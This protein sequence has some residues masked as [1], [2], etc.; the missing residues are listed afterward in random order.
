MQ[1]NQEKGGVVSRYNNESEIFWKKHLSNFAISGLKRV[2]YCQSQKI[3]YSR[4]SYWLAKLSPTPFKKIVN[5][6][7]ASKPLPLLSVQVTPEINQPDVLCSLTLKNGVTLKIH[8]LSALSFILAK[9][10]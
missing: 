2:E 10:I 3:S 8:D 9:V 4:F 7:S 1:A 5:E 6:H